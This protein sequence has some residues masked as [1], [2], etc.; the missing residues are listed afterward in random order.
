VIYVGTAGYSYEDWKGYFYPEDVR[1]EDML[2]LYAKEFNF[3]EV[4]STFYR[5]P[6]YPMMKGLDRKT[7]D[8]FKFVIKANR[9]IT[10]RQVSDKQV[11]D[12]SEKGQGA[13]QPKELSEVCKEFT[14]SLKPLSDKG[15]L[16]CVLLQFPWSFRHGQESIG[17]LKEVKDAMDGSPTVV[18]FRN[19]SWIRESVFQL[20]KE[21]NLAF[22]SVDEPK[23]KGLMPC[24]VAV[25][26]SIGYVRFHGRNSEKW[27]DHEH[28]WE[29]YNYLYSE[30]ELKE[31][32]PRIKEIQTKAKNTYVVMN[33]HYRGKAAQNAKMIQNLLQMRQSQ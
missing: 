9:D 15:K 26:S 29:R 22:C 14:N 8:G 4:N 6:S 27:W 21:L 2:A 11:S 18:E 19:S 3:V 1:S 24:V 16:G 12:K 13:S 28:S 25:T 33:N 31:W 30:E 5:M 32:V 17:F 7:K 10:H 20:L 23:L